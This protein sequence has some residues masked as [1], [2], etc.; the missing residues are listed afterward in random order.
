[1]GLNRAAYE[2]AITLAIVHVGL[3]MEEEIKKV[4]EYVSSENIRYELEKPPEDVIPLFGEHFYEHM[5]SMLDMNARIDHVMI[6]DGMILAQAD[7]NKN[8]LMKEYIDMEY[9][10]PKHPRF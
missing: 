6:S 4:A 9:F 8:F 10:W 2:G 7:T 1:M 3:I 5:K